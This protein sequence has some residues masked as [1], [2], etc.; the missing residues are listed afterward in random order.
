MLDIF[1]WRDTGVRLKENKVGFNKKYTSD[2]E[3]KSVA[4]NVLPILGFALRKG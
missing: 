1:F 3:T 2:P 4:R